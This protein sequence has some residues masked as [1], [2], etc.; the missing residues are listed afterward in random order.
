MQD[1]KRH[2]PGGVVNFGQQGMRMLDTLGSE[3]PTET[4]KQA[5]RGFLPLS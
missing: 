1:L 4:G 2:F 5:V 3:G